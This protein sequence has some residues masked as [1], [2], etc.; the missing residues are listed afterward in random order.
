MHE[1]RIEILDNA[2]SRE[3]LNKKYSLDQNGITKWLRI[4]KLISYDETL[5]MYADLTPWARTG[6]E[7]YGTSFEFT[8][9]KQKKQ[10]FVKALVTLSP[11][12]SLMDWS[13]RRG[14]LK[15]HGIAVSLWYH[16][17]DAIIFEEF[18][19]KTANEVTF[20]NILNIGNK[21]DEL[22]FI[23]LKFTDDIRA[24]KNGNPFFIDFGFDLGEPSNKISTNAKNYLL[25]KHPEKQNE[26]N[27][28]YNYK[29]TIKNK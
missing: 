19:P 6:A 16:Y 21:L 15:R 5:I 28:Y 22:G 4:N 23:T 10:I 25:E 7:T 14:I 2:A 26:I 9:N 17:A 20:E 24:D 27:N 18:Y 13:R 8:T 11:V 1:F 12:K 3:V 29:L